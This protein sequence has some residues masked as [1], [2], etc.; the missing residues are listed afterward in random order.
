MPV[1]VQPEAV[2]AVRGFNRLY[3]RRFG[4]LDQHHLGS[5]FTLGEVRVLYELA[6][7]GG[8]TAAGL[9]RSLEL[10]PGHLSRML[11][12]LV[13]RGLVRRQRSS[14]DR[15]SSILGLS[16]AGR[17][18]FTRLDCQAATQVAALLRSFPDSQRTELVQALSCVR[19]LLD[20]SG[21]GRPAVILRNHRPGDL[22][23]VLERH[24]AVY[25]EEYGWGAPFEAL[26]AEVIA[27][28]SR[29]HD[30]RREAC[31]LAELDGQRVGTVMLVR[32]TARPGVARLRLLLVEPE[33]R[34]MGVGRALAEACTEFARAAGYRKVTLWTQSVLGAARAIYASVGYRKVAE[35][36]NHEFGQGLIA[37]TWETDL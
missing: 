29:G 11:A 21:S 6:T 32:H 37:E 20:P 15:R 14:G 26:V 22:G 28:F 18:A 9:A 24:G 12:A 8:G 13:R 36:A 34:G 5:A 4:L 23:W 10:D 30:P 19:R 27:E 31:W 25:A 7:G 1:P 16:P 2:A 35:E 17:R 33:A 3:T